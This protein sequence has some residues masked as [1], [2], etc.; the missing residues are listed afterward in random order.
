MKTTIKVLSAFV[1]VIIVL[2]ALVSSG[3]KL[4]CS[5][6]QSGYESYTGVGISH[7]NNVGVTLR[8]S[9]GRTISPSNRS[10]STTDNGIKFTALTYFD[11]VINAGIYDVEVRKNASLIETYEIRVT[12]GQAPLLFIHCS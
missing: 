4:N 12:A 10:S 6:E 2:F 8:S 1:I 7:T 3:S 5:S 11:D 9:A